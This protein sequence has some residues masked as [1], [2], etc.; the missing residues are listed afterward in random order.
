MK[1]TIIICA[2]KEVELPK[3][4]YFLPIQAG[5]ELHQPI[6]GMQ[7]DNEGENISARN[8]HFC[9][10]TCHYWT[11][12]NAR[13]IVSDTDMQGSIW[14]LNHYRRFFDFGR[15]WKCFS[16]DRS[17]CSTEDFFANGY[18]MPGTEELLKGDDIILP[19]KR[20]YPY[21]VTE[22]YAKWHIADDW[23]MLRQIISELTPEYTPAFEK[24][25]DR[26]NGYSGYNMF[27]TTW[28]WF[29][30]YSEWLFKILF[31]VERRCPPHSDPVQSRIYGYMS[32]RLINVF[33]EHHHLRIRHIPIIMPVDEDFRN[34]GNLRYTWWRI[35]D[36]IRFRLT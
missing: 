30:M 22:Q 11:W 9:E 3:H 29:N 27:V 20:Y 34:P 36:C 16:P 5:A 13:H 12:R 2:H 31:E 15:K 18:S 35:R 23:K 19:P 6:P 1:A 28:K 7:P 33:C 4:E 14:G 24:T 26:S 32:E 10:L 25:M 8:P 21:S 17:F